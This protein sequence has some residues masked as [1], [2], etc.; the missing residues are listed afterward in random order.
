[1][2]NNIY[3]SERGRV[4]SCKLMLKSLHVMTLSISDTAC[5]SIDFLQ[6][7]GIAT[8]MQIHQPLFFR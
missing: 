6:T 3:A 4:V 5:E 8:I 2:H 1:M 7:P